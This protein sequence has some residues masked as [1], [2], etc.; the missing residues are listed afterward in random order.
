MAA[1][2]T[3]VIG[4]IGAIQ[5]LIENFPMSIFELFGN[6]VYTSVIDFVMDVLK[7]LGVSDTILVDKLIELF[8]DVP[9]ASEVY[10]IMLTSKLSSFHS[11]IS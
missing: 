2:T 11:L 10:G 8:F 6:K 7:Q 9:N 1:T 4:T 3:E 5:T